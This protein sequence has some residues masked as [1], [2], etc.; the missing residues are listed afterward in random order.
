MYMYSVLVILY[1]YIYPCVDNQDG[2][3]FAG[4][5]LIVH[6]CTCTCCMYT[7][8]VLLTCI[9]VS[10]LFLQLSDVYSSLQLLYNSCQTRLRYLH[11]VQSRGSATSSMTRMT[12]SLSSCLSQPPISAIDV[13]KSILRYTNIY[14]YI[15]VRVHV[16]V[17]ACRC[18][19]TCTCTVYKF[20]NG[21]GPW[22]VLKIGSKWAPILITFSDTY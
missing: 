1:I 16:H 3:K 2:T 6:A 8:H 19:C 13:T 14:M 12:S 10:V 17:H 21:M 20:H 22:F 7:V 18:R 4:F 5:I 15:D 9:I 11:C